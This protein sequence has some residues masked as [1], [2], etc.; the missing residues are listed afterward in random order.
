MEVFDGPFKFSKIS[1]YR[2]YRK[3]SIF[4]GCR[5]GGFI[6]NALLYSIFGD[7]HDYYVE[8]Y[9]QGEF[10]KYDK[11]AGRG[12]KRPQG[13]Y[14]NGTFFIQAG[15]ISKNDNKNSPIYITIKTAAPEENKTYDADLH[16]VLPDRGTNYYQRGTVEFTQIGN[17]KARGSY[18]NGARGDF[19][20]EIAKK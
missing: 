9:S 3:L 4:S 11:G 7:S 2:N 18:R 20:I 10:H 1:F 14:K 19:Y 12:A 8:V 6:S 17:G 16:Y 5:A 13:S 15:H